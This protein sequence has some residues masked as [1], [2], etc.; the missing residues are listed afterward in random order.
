M[1]D[2]NKKKLLYEVS[3]IRPIVIF[4]LVVMRSFTMYSGGWKKPEGI[5][6][7]SIYYWFVKFITGF[8]IE[9]IALVSGYV[10][11]YQSVELHRKYDFL[12]FALKKFKRL[13]I[14]GF[15]FS[16][17]Y[18]FIFRFDA[19][20]F[21]TLKWFFDLTSGFG[22]LWFLPMLFWCFILIW[23]IDKYHLSSK[24]LFL[25]LA[26]CSII[27][28]PKLPF[29]ISR[30]FHFAF[31]CYLGYLLFINKQTLLKRFLCFKYIV[32]LWSFYIALVIILNYVAQTN[33][34]YLILNAL[35]LLIAC[36]GIVALYLLVCKCVSKPNFTPQSWVLNA[37]AICYGVYV[38]HQFILQY[39]Y[40][41]TSLPI[42]T[43]TYLL[44][45]I[46]CSI[47][48][49]LSLWLTKLSLKTKMGRFLI[50]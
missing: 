24:L 5:D 46:G 38:Y 44:P 43:G 21:G 48:L 50:G 2:S 11:A 10:F 7:V 29:G 27:Y 1:A 37:S 6:D 13:I 25:V 30:M 39:L 9:T 34:T 45:W 40:Y 28:I 15:V 8:R 32:L 26:L 23:I 20:S 35:K 12:P 22:H 49:V 41:H 14:P 33:C 31:Y 36:S 4:L 17:L 42:V 47:T 19:N 18:Y 16:L 3:I